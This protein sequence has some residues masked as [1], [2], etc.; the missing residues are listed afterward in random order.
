MLTAAS[1]Y[2][3]TTLLEQTLESVARPFAWVGCR[4]RDRRAGLLLT[5]VME[6]IAKAAPGAADS[7]AERLAA[8]PEQFD[9]RLVTA[10]LIDDLSRLLVD[11]LVLV[12]DDAEQLDGAE[13]S[14]WLVGEL[15]RADVG[16]LRVAVSS[17]RALDLRLARDRARG[18]VTEITA[19]DLA[20]DAAD[21]AALLRA[22]TGIEA[23]ADRIGEVLEATEGW[24]LGVI[25]AVSRA[26]RPGG[27]HALGSAPDLRAYISEELLGDLDANLRRAAIASSVAPVVTPAVSAA[28]DLP[29]GFAA[30][31]EAAGMVL[32]PVGRTGAFSYHPLL[33]EVMLTRLVQDEGAAEW[34]RLHALVAPAVAADGDP[35]AAIEHWLEAARWDQAA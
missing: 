27:L 5:R 16:G 9:I 21:C 34:R 10:E 23:T 11:P 31:M 28:L 1:G 35:I 32:R 6:A 14:L 33:R 2:G 29:D 18:R 13:D 15:I 4:E 8:T 25:L 26:D 20:F 22:R 3:K 24:P 17:R 19:R 7:L 12:F 30:R